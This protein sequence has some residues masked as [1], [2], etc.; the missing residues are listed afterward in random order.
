MVCPSSVRDFMLP[1]MDI[2]LRFQGNCRRRHGGG[3]IILCRQSD[4]PTANGCTCYG[5]ILR[6]NVWVVNRPLTIA[7]HSDTDSCGFR[8]YLENRLYTPLVPFLLVF[9]RPTSCEIAQITPYFSGSTYFIDAMLRLRMGTPPTPRVTFVRA[10]R[11]NWVKVAYSHNL[12]NLD[13][14]PFIGNN[15]PSVQKQL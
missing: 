8:V 12:S 4:V 10:R 6:T 5:S 1:C 11:E 3:R 9:R 13:S 15:T 14:F 7:L 2:G